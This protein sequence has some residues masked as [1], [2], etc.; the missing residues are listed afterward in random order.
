[1]PTV[2][3]NGVETYYER[4]GEGPSVILLH[5]ATGNHR[6]W[7]QHAEALADDYEVIRY[8]VRG[9]GR[10]EGSDLDRYSIGL[11]ADDLHALV[12]TLDV[13]APRVCGLSLGGLTA[14]TYA[15][16][17]P[18][19]LSALAV[20]GTVT[21]EPQSVKERVAWGVMTRVLTAGLRYVGYDRIKAAEQWLSE[22]LGE[23][24]DQSQQQR[25]DTDSD[26]ERTIEP[27][28]D[29]KEYA[30]VYSAATTYRQTPILME[31]ISVPTLV[32][33]GENEPFIEDH[34]PVYR[35]RLADVTVHHIPNASHNSHEQNP[36]AF[37]AALTE[38]FSQRVSGEQK[39]H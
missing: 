25:E 17:Y 6:N 23:D 36:D 14:L 11:F 27:E 13:D 8:D 20:A 39:I 28:P 4:E 15:A 7:E 35:R 2:E 5:G 10:T 24:R 12:E 3:T 38:F 16:R 22:R 9:H 33:Y 19:D 26:G 29:S 31:N 34:L 18:D 37:T 1:M 30:K 32:I 21:P